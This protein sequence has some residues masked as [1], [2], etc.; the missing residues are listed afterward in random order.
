M[1]SVSDPNEVT[2][3][4]QSSV[5]WPAFR[6]LLDHL[7][8]FKVYHYFLGVF[9]LLKSTKIDKNLTCF[10][11]VVTGF[12]VN[13]KSCKQA[14]GLEEAQKWGLI[15]STNLVYEKSCNDS[16]NT[17]TLYLLPKA[18]ISGHLHCPQK[19]RKIVSHSVACCVQILINDNVGGNTRQFLHVYLCKYPNLTPII[20]VTKKLINASFFYQT[21]VL[22]CT[23]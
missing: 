1:V 5:I 22:I 14:R 18:H 12:A 17:W 4:A 2:F 10:L 8:T 23:M 21:M 15:I 13:L 16:V 20:L 7:G 11:F 3:S 6:W 9:L 19:S